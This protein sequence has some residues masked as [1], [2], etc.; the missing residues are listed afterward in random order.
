MHVHKQLL[1]AA[2]LALGGTCAMVATPA[3]ARV[4]VDIYANVAPPPL[5]AEIVPAPRRGYV[6]VPGY[7]GWSHHRHHWNR[8]HWARERRGYHY[9]PSRWDR[10]GD[11]WRYY[12]GR[13]E[14]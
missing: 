4:H 3:Q 6:W 11:R 2:A 13:W 1:L 14:R 8:G 7:W 9:V 5:R 10:D 12:G